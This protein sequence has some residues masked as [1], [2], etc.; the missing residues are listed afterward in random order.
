MENLDIRT[1]ELWSSG[2]VARFL[3]VKLGRVQ[4]LVKDYDIPHVMTSS[5]R[6]FLK[7]DIIRL[8]EQRKDKLKHRKKTI[9]LMPKKQ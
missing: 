2:D 1:L 4:T 8:Q 5:G 9:L 3:N 6:I 7:S